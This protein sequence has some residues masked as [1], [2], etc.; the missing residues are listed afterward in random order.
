MRDAIGSSEHATNTVAGSHCDSGSRSSNSQPRSDLCRRPRVQIVR[1]LCETRKNHSERFQCFP[2]QRIGIRQGPRRTEGFVAMSHSLR[3]IG[4][5][6]TC[7][8]S[9]ICQSV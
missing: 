7:R 1:H 6:R 4:W 3:R 8:N 5:L 2:R 9:R